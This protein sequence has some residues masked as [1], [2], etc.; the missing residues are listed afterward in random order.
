[1]KHLCDFCVY[2]NGACPYETDNRKVSILK[3]LKFDSDYASANVTNCP[4]F[5][6]TLK[7]LE[8]PD[9]YHDDPYNIHNQIKH[10]KATLDSA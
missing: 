7:K 3:G 6:R 1:M 8:I 5:K 9:I 10:N 4:T 2:V